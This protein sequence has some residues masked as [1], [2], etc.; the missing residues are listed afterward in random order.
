MVSSAYTEHLIQLLQR[1]AF[2]LRD[3]EEDAEE[4]DQVPDRVPGEGALGLEG[5]QERGPG[6]GQDEVEE[7]CCG[8]GEGHAL[9][10]D[11]ERVGFGGVGEWDG[12]FAGGVHD[13]EEVEAEGDA[14]DAGG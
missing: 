4:A 8:G 3:E 5:F 6:D 7:P 14:G 9:G 10:A 12:A 11:V 2:G 13:T 1:L